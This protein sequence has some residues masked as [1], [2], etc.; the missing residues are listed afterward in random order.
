MR[1]LAAL[2]VVLF[3]AVEGKHIPLLQAAMPSWCESLIRHGHLGVAVFFVLSGFVI[4]HSLN[5]IRVTFPVAGRFMVRR[6]IR[7]DPPYWAA[8]V[9]ALAFALISSKVLPGKIGPDFTVPQILG[10]SSTRRR[11]LNSLHK[12]RMTSEVSTRMW[13]GIGVNF[14][15]FAPRQDLVFTGLAG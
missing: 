8:I 13:M 14:E 3:H 15:P 7:L 2:A 9:V 12:A 10:P 4:S 5:D 11:S 1:G 6:S